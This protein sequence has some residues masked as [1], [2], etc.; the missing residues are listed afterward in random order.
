MRFKKLSEDLRPCNVKTN[1]QRAYDD[2]TLYAPPATLVTTG[3]RL[4][5]VGIFRDAHVVC[6]AGP[7]LLWS[8]RLPDLPEMQQPIETAPDIL[9]PQPLVAKKVRKANRKRAT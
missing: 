4:D 3:Y 1:Q 6:W 9:P 7:E 8:L 5:A 2:Q